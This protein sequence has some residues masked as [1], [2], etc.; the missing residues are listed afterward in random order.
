MVYPEYIDPLA[1]VFSDHTNNASY[2]ENMKVLKMRVRIPTKML[3]PEYQ[4]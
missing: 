2:L 3:C 1:L 4:R